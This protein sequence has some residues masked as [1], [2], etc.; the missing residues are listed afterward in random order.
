MTATLDRH[1]FERTLGLAGFQRGE[2]FQVWRKTAGGARAVQ[3]TDPQIA[4]RFV[5]RGREAVDLYLTLNPVRLEADPERGLVGEA[6]MLTARMLNVDSDPVSAEPEAR[7]HALELAHETREYFRQIAGVVPPLIDSGRGHQLWLAHE[8][9]AAEAS[10]EVRELVLRGL[11]HF[12]R[13]PLARV[14]AAPWGARFA[15][16]LPG[17]INS[18]TGDRAR[19]VDPG[20]G[21]V[22]P[23]HVLVELAAKWRDQLPPPIEGPKKL[24]PELRSLIGELRTP[25]DFRWFG[26]EAARMH[27]HDVVRQGVP[28]GFESQFDEGAAGPN[29]RWKR[30]GDQAWV[31][32]VD[33]ALKKITKNTAQ[34]QAKK[35]QEALVERAVGE[36]ASIT[37]KTE[38][39]GRG[40]RFDLE[41]KVGSATCLIRGLDGRT[42]ELWPTVRARAAEEGLRFPN[43][44]GRA[45]AQAQVAWSAKLD[46]AWDHMTVEQLE[47]GTTFAALREQIR[48]YFHSSK[49]SEGESLGELRSGSWVRVA[50]GIAV[51]WRQ[52]TSEVQSRLAYDGV[53]RAQITEAAKSLGAVSQQPTLPDGR[54]ARAWVFPESILERE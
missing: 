16:R 54:R 11:A 30:P 34:A 32:R 26:A 19:I 50:E 45:A 22:M 29:R 9:I 14:D 35:E 53:D 5:G 24:S 37:R 28:H 27:V 51:D 25:D 21:V 17:T 40:A 18:K 7:E 48:A 8:P 12:R 2:R 42:I 20:N 39:A 43:L 49:N 6:D 46:A 36:I 33:T 10:L 1:L 13:R 31:N 23:W 47:D 41:L 38:G 44:I 4:L 52:L 15:G 3:T